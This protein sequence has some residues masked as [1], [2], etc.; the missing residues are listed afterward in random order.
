LLAKF[1]S[2]PTLKTYLHPIPITNPAVT[3]NPPTFFVENPLITSPNPI[4]PIPN[5]AVLLAPIHLTI[6]AFTSAK[7][8]IHAAV[9]LPTKDKL[10]GEE[11]F[12]STRAAWITPHE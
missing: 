8:E 11:S 5:I 4:A 1:L 9:K 3:N 10:A 12:C 2:H 6:L 7:N